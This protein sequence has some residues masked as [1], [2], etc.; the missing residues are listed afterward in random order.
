[1]KLPFLYR[2][3]SFSQEGEDL[4]LQK[5]FSRK[6]DG[7]YVDVGAHHPYRYSNTQLLHLKGW[8]GINIDPNYSIKLFDIARP[9]DINIR[10]GV[11]DRSKVLT[12]YMFEDSALD[13]F[14]E[15]RAETIVSSGQAKRIGTTKV[16]VKPLS[17]VLDKHC[18]DS[19]IN[20][21]NIDTEGMDIEV[22]KSNNWKK[23]RP[24]VIVIESIN[25]RQENT[26]YKFLKRY[27][28]KLR[29]KT[30]N[31]LIFSHQAS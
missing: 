23:Y 20:L 12:L 1:M 29:A 10:I 2:Q 14:I 28:Y 19:A 11:A 5:I 3:K 24:E 18:K 8:K 22:L 9:N 21:L 27:N 4:I 6:K 31:S 7:F 26:I 17:S 25:G 30:I 15:K 13:T 16:R